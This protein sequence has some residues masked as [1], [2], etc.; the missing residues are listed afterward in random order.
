VRIPD[1]DLVPARRRAYRGG[2]GSHRNRRRLRRRVAL[3]LVVL[4][5]AAAV[6][7]FV[8]HDDGGTPQAAVCVT[9]GPTRVP[10]P[11]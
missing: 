7:W 6:A 8:R 5:V 3:V 9:A 2:Y 4:L 1:G 11:A 10:C